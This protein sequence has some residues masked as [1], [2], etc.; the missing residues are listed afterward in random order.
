MKRAPCLREPWLRR[1][2]AEFAF[3]LTR[4]FGGIF[5]GWA[6]VYAGYNVF[7]GDNTASSSIAVFSIILSARGD[8][9]GQG[10][11]LTPKVRN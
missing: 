2:I 7:R 4:W 5:K 9:G 6:A 1:E 3:S 11:V 8:L 10:K